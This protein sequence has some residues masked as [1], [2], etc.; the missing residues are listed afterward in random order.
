M[1]QAVVRK[2][3]HFVGIITKLQPENPTIYI[4]DYMYITKT[5]LHLTRKHSIHIHCCALFRTSQV[6][7][8]FY[9]GFSLQ[10]RF[11]VLV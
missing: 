10:H 11:S 2:I 9:L 5:R 6:N 7:S 8:Q 4:I 3:T 1:A